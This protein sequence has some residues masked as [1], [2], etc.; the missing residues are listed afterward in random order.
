MSLHERTPKPS[1]NSNPILVSSLQKQGQS[2]SSDRKLTQYAHNLTQIPVYNPA[3]A[4]QP[5]LTIGQP[6]D[7]YEREADNVAARVMNM[8]EAIQRQE[9]LEEEEDKLQLKASDSNLAVNTDTPTDSLEQQLNRS[10]G[11]CNPLSGEAKSFMQPRFGAE[12]NDVR[13]HTDSNAVQMSQSIQA[14]AFTHGRD[15]HFNSGKYN[16]ST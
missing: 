16:P 11:G 5:K 3:T 4:V 10:Q 6:G 13:T 8:P 15:I 9:I 2:P 7:K 12:F 14:Q 1:F